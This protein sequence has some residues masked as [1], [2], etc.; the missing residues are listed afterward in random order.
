MV[1]RYGS[2]D[3]VRQHPSETWRLANEVSPFLGEHFN[4]LH[5]RDMDRVPLCLPDTGPH[6]DFS[7]QQNR[8]KP[9]NS[10]AFHLKSVNGLFGDICLQF[11]RHLFTL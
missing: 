7:D 9:P 11:W 5:S 10:Q 1:F 4:Q 3:R 8:Q 6:S 2:R